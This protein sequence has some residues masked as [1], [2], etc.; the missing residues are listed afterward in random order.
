VSENDPGSATGNEVPIETF[1]EASAWLSRYG[2]AGLLALD[3]EG[4][5]MFRYRTQ[6]C[7]VQLCAERAICVIDTLRVPAAP[8]L[9][10]VLGPDGPQ[11]II[12]DA[13]FDARI[14]FAHGVLLANVFDTAVA[15]R[16]LG[17]PSTGLS[18]LLLKLFGVNLPKHQQQADWGKRPIDAEAMRYLQDDVRYLPALFER[19]LDEVRAHDIEPV[20]RVEC[21]YLLGEAQRAERVEAAWMRVKGSALRPPHERARLYEL[22]EARE[23][24][25]RE[26]DLPPARLLPSELLLRVAQDDARE[27]MTLRRL[28]GNKADLA[29]ALEQALARAHG[30]ADA[31]RDQVEAMLPEPPSPAELTR[32]KRRKA[33]LSE[34]RAREAAA[35]GVDAQVVLPGHCLSDIIDLETIEEEALRAVPGFGECRFARYG[36]ALL[37]MRA[38]LGE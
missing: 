21:A 28:L 20:V 30:V 14:L 22:A 1:A 2:S 4:D 19:L 5:G 16:F 38:A 27:P 35:R 29:P 33:W 25:A 32:K 34:F 11:K 23:Q 18:S 26:R 8:L 12:H 13:S 10:G 7:S 6:L 36:R 9:S 17:F 24:L 37:A 31:P 3:T 15:A